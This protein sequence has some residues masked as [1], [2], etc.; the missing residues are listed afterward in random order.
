MPSNQ[1][2]HDH[3][4]HETRLAVALRE[5]YTLLV[6]VEPTLIRD[7]RNGP[8][9]TSLRYKAMLRDRVR[10]WL[11]PFRDHFDEG[12]AALLGER[13]PAV[14]PEATH[15]CEACGA[16]L[17]VEDTHYSI[18]AMQYVCPTP[19]SDGSRYEL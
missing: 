1:P 19:R 8:N 18:G 6:S 14:P 12:L 4:E 7:A 5:A 17:S 10:V 11:D 2:T 9:P 15:R 13:A 3:E 16:A